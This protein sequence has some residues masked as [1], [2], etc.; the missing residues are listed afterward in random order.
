[1]IPDNTYLAFALAVSSLSEINFYR[2]FVNRDLLS[3]AHKESGSE[4]TRRS[5]VV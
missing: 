2:S 4:G 3:A 5:E 1:M